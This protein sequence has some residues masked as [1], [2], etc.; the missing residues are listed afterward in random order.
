MGAYKYFI[1]SVGLYSQ[2]Q[3]PTAAVKK[4]KNKEEVCDLVFFKDFA[5][6]GKSMSST[7][8]FLVF[9]SRFKGRFSYLLCLPRVSCLFYLL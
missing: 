3:C 5:L 1:P 4:M 9:S 8:V 2:L 6:G 7:L